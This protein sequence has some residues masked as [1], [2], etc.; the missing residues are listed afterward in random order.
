MNI[1]LQNGSTSLRLG[2]MV[3]GLQAQLAD[4]IQ[5]HHYLDVYCQNGEILRLALSGLFLKTKASS[6]VSAQLE[7]LSGGIGWFFAEIGAGLYSEYGDP[8]R[9]SNRVSCG[10]AKKMHLISFSVAFVA[11]ARFAVMG[12][13]VNVAALGLSYALKVLCAKQI[14]PISTNKIDQG[15]NL[16]ASTA[17]LLSKPA[18]FDFNTLVS[19]C[20]ISSLVCS[21]LIRKEQPELK[22]NSSNPSLNL[23]GEFLRH[24]EK[25]KSLN[26]HNRG[27]DLKS[28]FIPTKSHIRPYYPELEN[29]KS[30]INHLKTL[31]EQVPWFEQRDAVIAK[32]SKDRKFLENHWELSSIDD[33]DFYQLP[34]WIDL[35]RGFYRFVDDIA[36]QNSFKDHPDT[37]II[38]EYYCRYLDQEIGKLIK[39]NPI[40]AYDHL[41]ELA[42]TAGEYCPMGQMTAV[43]QI[44]NSF[45]SKQ[46]PLSCAIAQAL[47]DVRLKTFDEFYANLADLTQG[48]QYKSQKTCDKLKKL[49]ARN[50][51]AKIKKSICSAYYQ[52]KFKVQSVV[53][54]LFAFDSVHTYHMVRALLPQEHWGINDVGSKIEFQS[55][56]NSIERFIIQSYIWPISTMYSS[57]HYSSEKIVREMTSEFKN[58]RLS[59]QQLFDWMRSKIEQ[60]RDHLSPTEFEMLMEQLTLTEGNGSFFGIP[61]PCGDDSIID[62]RIIILLALDLGIIESKKA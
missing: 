52:T 6:K 23:P 50:L 59:K 8:K 31:F 12:L 45:V 40:A 58:R 44:F 55:A 24:I 29:E 41:L 61:T 4:S 53:S 60:C 18:L 25:V 46:S 11:I 22:N 21:K 16:V 42:V 32:L 57:N 54:K 26:F 43:G 5:G 47:H 19:I 36:H 35:K 56:T 20:D 30:D 28:N 33:T 10:F 38:M 3:G 1:N 15:L 37:Q 9:L 62:S 39:T 7:S 14:I 27:S 34:Y 51:F 13:W 48:Y 17:H 2:K 49:K